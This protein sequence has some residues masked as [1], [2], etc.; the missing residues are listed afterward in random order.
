[1]E[2]AWWWSKQ[3]EKKEEK[4]TVFIC[5]CYVHKEKYG[6]SNNL[7]V[8][9]CV[10]QLVPKHVVREVQIL[11]FTSEKRKRLVERNS[12]PIFFLTNVEVSQKSFAH[13]SF[14][15]PK[16]NDCQKSFPEEKVPFKKVFFPKFVGAGRL[17]STPAF[18]FRSVPA[19]PRR[20]TFEKKLLWA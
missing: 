12:H 10:L 18:G 19:P 3:G 20:Q 15:F 1:M 5:H 11:L 7:D 4:L 2:E 13:K 16:L 8:L 9:Y 14:V 17:H 6:D